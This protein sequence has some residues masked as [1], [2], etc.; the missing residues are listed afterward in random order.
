MIAKKNRAILWVVSGPSGSG[1]TTLCEKLIQQDKL[2]IAR[3][4]SY[5]TRSLRK[6]EK[7]YKDYI[8]VARQ[9]FRAK[10]EKGEFLEW[11][12]VFGNLY[13]TSKRRVRSLLKQ[14]KDVLLC[15]DV[16][17]AL[18]IKH[19]FPK[20]TVSIFVVPPN[21]KELKRRIK[22]RAREG[23]RELKRRLAFAKTELSFA[24]QY[25]Y[26]IVNDDLN[27]ALEGLESIIMA[28]RLKN[29]IRTD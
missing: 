19:K 29:V 2:N 15:I 22:L 1:K 5:T 16:Q 7:N 28:E 24:K 10:I 23:R 9:A 18:E 26:I 13:G 27:K 25:D 17:G 11:K 6:G 3:S 20:Q 14:N 12:E 21:V 4:I 8:F